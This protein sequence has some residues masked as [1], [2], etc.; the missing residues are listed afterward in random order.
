MSEKSI[1]EKIAEGELPSYKVWEDDK[2]M[3]FLSIGPVV[4]GH[5]LVIPKKNL[6]DYLFDMENVDYLELM[7]A[8]KKV[9]KVLKEKIECDRVGVWVEG[10]EVPHVHIHLLPMKK[11]FKMADA[12]PGT[13]T[14]EEF[15]AVL[16]KIKN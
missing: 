6:A 13:A 15:E 5:T 4:E 7:Q 3:A 10:F 1:F 16:A 12:T 14:P 8:S 2:Y 9:A 11:G